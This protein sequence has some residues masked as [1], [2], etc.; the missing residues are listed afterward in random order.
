MFKTDSTGQIK[1]DELRDKVASRREALESA[2]K[3]LHDFRQ[4]SCNRLKAQNKSKRKEWKVI[5]EKISI[6]RR[7]LVR[8]CIVL[9]RLRPTIYRQDN[10]KTSYSFEIGNMSLPSIFHLRGMFPGM[11]KDNSNV[12]DYNADQINHVFGVLANLTALVAQYLGIKLPYMI[13]LPMPGTPITSISS[14]A[15]IVSPFSLWLDD[16]VQVF[17]EALARLTID[18][19]YLCKSQDVPFRSDEDD[20]GKMLYSLLTHP[21]VGQYSD[22]TAYSIAQDKDRYSKEKRAPLWDLI[23][24]VDK[25]AEDLSNDPFEMVELHLHQS[26]SSTISAFEKVTI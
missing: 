26:A 15:T 6:E 16:D 13:I 20:L 1:V 25:I 14:N 12:I 7:R 23:K 11:M 9:H 22:D 17:A 18:I 3:S 10:A 4:A 8:S 21:T 19:Q 5:S 24:L 2:R